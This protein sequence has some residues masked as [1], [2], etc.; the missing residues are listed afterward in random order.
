M[1]ESLEYEQIWLSQAKVLIISG[2]DYIQF[3]DFHAQTILNIIQDRTS[4]NL[5][6]YIVSPKIT[7]L[8]G[9]GIFFGRLKQI[10]EGGV[11]K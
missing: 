4:H 10:M 3:K 9:S 11:V 2:L 6:T 7:T 1:P 8:V 5:P